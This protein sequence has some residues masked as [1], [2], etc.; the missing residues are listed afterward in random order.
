MIM[1]N[2][3]VTDDFYGGFSADIIVRDY[4]TKGLFYNGNP[5]WHVKFSYRAIAQFDVV[6]K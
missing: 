6:K 5:T 4:P 3:I 1:K 2:V